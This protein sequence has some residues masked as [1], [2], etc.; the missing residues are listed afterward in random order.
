MPMP[1]TRRYVD[2]VSGSGGDDA[3]VACFQ[4]DSLGLVSCEISYADDRRE[5]LHVVDQLV[6]SR[7]CGNGNGSIEQAS[8]P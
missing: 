6:P 2:G 8:A 7:C 4:S 3:T 5:K 1:L